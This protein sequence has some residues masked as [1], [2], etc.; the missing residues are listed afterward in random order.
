MVT[1]RQIPGAYCP[2]D[3]SEP[4]GAL[5]GTVAGELRDV[6]AVSKRIRI[7]SL[8]VAVIERLALVQK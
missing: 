6:R 3:S 1:P 4:R 7:P 2:A 8:I 5:R